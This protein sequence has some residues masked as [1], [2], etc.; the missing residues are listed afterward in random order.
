MRITFLVDDASR[1]SGPAIAVFETAG[2]LDAR[3]HAVTIATRSEPPDWIAPRC[4]VRQSAAFG[5]DLPEAD[6][7]VAVE[8]DVV[9]FAV[10]ARG[11]GVAVH[12]CYGFEG[13][14]PEALPHRTRIERTYRSAGAELVVVSRHVAELVRT[15]FERSARLL[16]P[17][18]DRS[19][20][21]PA[22]PR[23]PSQPVRVGIVG[24]DQSAWK[25][26]ATG[27]EAC[28]LA[29]AG[30][31]DLVLVR[32][33]G[34][35]HP[36]SE[37][38]L[39]LPIEWHE[40]VPP[41]D[42]GEIYR[43][44]DVLLGTTLASGAALARSVLEA[45]ACGVPCVLTEVPCHTEHGDRQTALFV[46]PQQPAQMAEALRLVAEHPKVRAEL[47]ENGIRATD[48]YSLDAHA[49][50]LEAV[51]TDLVADARPVFTPQSAQPCA[52]DAPT[53]QA[54]DAVRRAA[55]EC[56]TVEQL[57]ELQARIAAAFAAELSQ[58][59]APPPVSS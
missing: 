40:R 37:C 6:V 13:D 38:G 20:V 28:R 34:N 44:L 58:R 50:Q 46:E 9:P 12:L 54:V 41:A 35:G 47:R 26:V 27:I 24:D 15:R 45:M 52:V 5:D 7:V 11:A 57:D 31:L 29:R 48:G 30:G 42:M 56:N 8:W 18:L 4:D 33:A 36:P 16:T 51:F 39:D 23:A 17:P 10:A 25:D 49:E 2:A 14:R 21:F 53:S 32:V 3:G 59:R 22:E 55:A 1:I 19:V 43:G